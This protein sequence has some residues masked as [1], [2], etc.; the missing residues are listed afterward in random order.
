MKDRYLEI[1]YRRGKLVAAYLYLPRQP[2]EKVK[3]TS[4]AA[5]GVLVDYNK[6][7]KPIGVEITAPQHVSWE[8]IN[9][10]ILGLNL[11]PV[12]KEELA[13]LRAA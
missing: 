13:P 7:G 12:S 6:A 5:E 1:T 10:I 3:R 11:P 4:K 2:R 9:Q 8:V